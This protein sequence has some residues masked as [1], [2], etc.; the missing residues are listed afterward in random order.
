M[1][2]KIARMWLDAKLWRERRYQET[3]VYTSRKVLETYNY[4]VYLQVCTPYALIECLDKVSR[5]LSEKTIG[6]YGIQYGSQ[7]PEVGRIC[8]KYMCEEYTEQVILPGVLGIC[9]QYDVKLLKDTTVVPEWQEADV[10][11]FDMVLSK[12]YRK[13]LHGEIYVPSIKGSEVP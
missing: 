11:W 13:C 10:Q 12:H 8:V 5:Y 3:S 1:I 2:K 9:G 6:N 4:K 7:P